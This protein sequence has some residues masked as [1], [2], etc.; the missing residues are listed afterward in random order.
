LSESTRCAE[1]AAALAQEETKTRCNEKI[2]S[3]LPP[4]AGL[5]NPEFLNSPDGRIL[6]I[7]SEYYEPMTRFAAK[8]NPGHVVFFGSARFRALRRG[9]P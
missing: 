2:L 4:R 8:R 1:D 5:R 3:R 9:K 7:V 6:R